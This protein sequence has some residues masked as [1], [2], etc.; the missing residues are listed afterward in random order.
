[1][2]QS[3]LYSK[4]DVVRRLQRLIDKYFG[5]WGLI[6]SHRKNETIYEKETTSMSQWNLEKRLSELYAFNFM[7]IMAIN[8]DIDEKNSTNNV[9]KVDII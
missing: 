5:G 1:M 3:C 8:V 6:G 2:Y 4:H 9:I 7:P